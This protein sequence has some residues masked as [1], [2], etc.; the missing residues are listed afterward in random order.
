MLWEVLHLFSGF[1]MFDT[2][3]YLLDRR[4]IRTNCEKPST[5]FID[6]GGQLNHIITYYFPLKRTPTLYGRNNTYC[7]MDRRLKQSAG[8]G[9]EST[10]MAD[11]WEQS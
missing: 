3:L 7:G 9:R 1:N 4:A 11:Q 2:G 8:N 10:L 6:C 5:A